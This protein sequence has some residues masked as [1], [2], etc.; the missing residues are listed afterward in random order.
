MYTPG[1]FSFID[2]R[3]ERA[4]LEDAYRAVSS[5]DSWEIMKNNPDGFVAL[6]AAMKYPRHSHTSY[7]W[8]MYHMQR[9]ARLGWDTY[10]LEYLCC[11]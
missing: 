8:T 7:A 2:V 5:T 10:I 9:I 6:K 3:D 11:L 4:M 1:D